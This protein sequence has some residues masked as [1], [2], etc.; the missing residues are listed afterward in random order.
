MS[1]MSWPSFMPS[2]AMNSFAAKSLADPGLATANT[3][4]RRSATFWIPGITMT[5]DVSL[6]LTQ[7]VIAISPSLTRVCTKRRTGGK[8]NLYVAGEQSWSTGR[9]RQID[10]FHLQAVLFE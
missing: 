6:W 4:P 10:W 9:T 1:E 3:L 7:E 5:F 2:R 8:V